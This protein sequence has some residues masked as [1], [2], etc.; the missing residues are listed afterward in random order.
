[1]K[2]RALSLISILIC[3]SIFASCFSML[4]VISFGS[5][6][7]KAGDT[8]DIIYFGSYP[9]S[10]V[11]DATLIEN[12][13]NIITETD[14]KSYNYFSG[15]GDYESS[16]SYISDYG[17]GKME[18]SDYMKYAD[19]SYNGEKYR[20]VTFSTYRKQWTGFKSNKYTNHTYQDNNGYY[21]NKV[22]WF[23][24]DPIEWKVLDYDTGL[25]MCQ[26]LIDSQP[27]TNYIDIDMFNYDFYGDKD[28]LYYANNYENSSIRKW[29]NND[30]YNTAF[31]DD[32]KENIKETNISTPSYSV[33]YSIY[34]SS[35]V[36]DRVFLL[37]YGDLL[38]I[39][40]GFSTSVYNDEKRRISG[41]DYALSQGLMSGSNP[42]SSYYLRTAGNESRAVCSVSSDGYLETGNSADGTFYGVCPAMCIQNV[43]SE[44]EP[45]TVTFISEGQ[46]YKTDECYAGKL[47]KNP[48]QPIREDYYFSGWYKD[49]EFSQFFDL[50]NDVITEDTTLYAG[51]SLVGNGDTFTFGS[52]P[53]SE[54]KDISLINEL[55]TNLDKDNWISYGYY[56]GS[57]HEDFY[58]FDGQMKPYDYMRYQ[59]ITYNGQKYRAVTFDSY[60]SM[61]TTQMSSQSTDLTYQA[62]NGYYINEVY[63]FVFEPITWRVL[64]VA[65]GLVVSSLILDA[66]AYNNYIDYSYKSGYGYEYWGNESKNYKANNY[67]NSSIRQWLNND[68]YNTAFTSDEK[69]DVIN[70][71]IDITDYN[72]YYTYSINDNV[73]LPKYESNYF[74]TNPTDYSRCQGYGYGSSYNARALSSTSYYERYEIRT[75]YGAY[76]YSF[77]TAYG[78]MPE[79]RLNLV[80]MNKND[81]NIYNCD[82][83]RHNYGEW[84]ISYEPTCSR[85]GDKYRYC[86]ICNYYDHYSIEPIEHSYGEWAVEREATCLTFGS[87]HTDCIKCGKSIWETIDLL[88]HTDSDKDGFCDLCNNTLTNQYISAGRCGQDV[89]WKLSNDGQLLI[90]GTGLMA[91]YD[92]NQ[93][94]NID[95]TTTSQYYYKPTTANKETTTSGQN[96]ANTFKAKNEIILKEGDYTTGI[97]TTGVDQR[98]DVQYTL[99]DINGNTVWNSGYETYSDWRNYKGA[100]KEVIIEEGVTNVSN[101]AFENCRNLKSVRLP[102]TLTYIGAYAFE[103]CI[104]L[105]EICIPENV[106]SVGRYALA[107]CKNLLTMTLNAEN[108]IFDNNT[109]LR[110][111]GIKTLY[112]AS[113]VKSIPLLAS[114]ERVE[115]AEGTLKVCDYAFYEDSN[116]KY[117]Y[118]PD[119]I[120]Y[121]GN[122]AFYDCTNLANIELP[123]SV[124]YI[125]DR[126]FSYCSIEDVTIPEAVSYIG[127]SAF[128]GCP[129]DNIT[130]PNNVSYIGQSAFSNC[131][132]ETIVI[133]ENVSFIGKYAFANNKLK[134]IYFNAV[135][136]ESSYAFSSKNNAE[137]VY[138]GDKVKRIDALTFSGIDNL[139]R[140]YIPDTAIEIHPL[141][142]NDCGYASIVCKDGS[143]ANAYAIQNNMRYILED[144]TSGT[145][146]NIKNGYLTTYDGTAKNVVV[147][148]DVN[149]I[150]NNAFKGNKSVKTIELPYSVTKIY[151][152]AFAECSKL[153]YVVI[154]FTVTS[155]GNDAFS[156]N[157]KIYCY[158]GSYAYNYAKENNLAFELIT[159]EFTQTKNIRVND[160]VTVAVKPNVPLSSG[161]PLVFDSSD[162]SIVSINSSGN[163]LGLSVGEATITASTIDGVVVGECNVTVGEK[164]HEHSYKS[165]LITAPTC[166]SEGKANFVCEC[167]ESYIE[168]V[169]STGHSDGDKDGYCDE[170]KTVIDNTLINPCKYA[171]INV[172]AE[173]TVDYKS[174]V[175]IKAT[176]TEIPSGYY[177]AI[178]VNDKQV[179]KGNNTEVTYE[180]GQITSDIN[181]TVKVIDAKDNVQS[182]GK[183]KELSKD[184]KVTCN[185][186]FFKKI[187][188]FFKGLF[189]KL[190]SVVV[191]P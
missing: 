48:G 181:Y 37:S 47:I 153:E 128:V 167:G 99:T 168:A 95:Y 85:Y 146:F 76:G 94:T 68:F 115:F 84:I 142:F 24:Y 56:S 170:C 80:S 8:E 140:I 175:T 113:N 64:D 29:L 49:A 135:D 120:E 163:M 23:K 171:K 134:E 103:E 133:P 43:Y 22:Y 189:G 182:D 18:P 57:S 89:Y 52:Y 139:E 60:R 16:D 77:C 35:D 9:Q 74:Y 11:A 7:I 188:A 6:N 152:G 59:D 104:S 107:N 164:L 101:S 41:T 36:N 177:L 3:I 141:A 183:G 100:I 12:L 121:I 127:E 154:P 161:L 173:K 137:L 131:Q 126:A 187:I 119:T 81:I 147:S 150:G 136:C 26:T 105:E 31:S 184:S 19:I 21:I 111:T 83:G 169:P 88:S 1:M 58:V 34:N 73:F 54:V 143:Y 10:K 30:F 39:N 87:K 61:Y 148:S 78:I 162:T 72:G 62:S 46:I 116:L 13:N 130:I 67:E 70:S 179:A 122:Y 158:Y 79:I 65:S 28:G 157:T 110:G 117:V 114:L 40:Y 108:A 112:V 51:W 165:E 75:L 190:P 178:F 45:C 166:D 44:L 93:G 38:N 25:I 176:A 27:Y 14:W 90:Y 124:N 17:Y 42:A 91:Y 118:L 102:S 155:I 98:T 172:A 82:N 5:Q 69:T 144:S 151:S 138:I 92:Y 129:I 185:S 132:L 86:L 109:T 156:S 50:E 159:V 97:Y 63:W 33:N 32:Q 145:A 2:R 66:Q 106:T 174:K 123:K 180:A 71:I 191:K 186:G 96:S 4:S 53:Q 160:I 125:G 20:A 55:N 15:T 149:A